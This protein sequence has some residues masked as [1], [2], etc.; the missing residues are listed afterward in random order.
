MTTKLSIFIKVMLS[1]VILTGGTH[2]FLYAQQNG[3]VEKVTDFIQKNQK[4]A[5]E[6]LNLQFNKGQNSFFTNTINNDR[7]VLQPA[8]SWNLAPN[9]NPELNLAYNN[10]GQW[11]GDVNGD[12][13][14]DYIFRGFPREEDT[15]ELEDIGPKTL[16]FFGGNTSE[17][18][19]QIIDL[20]VSPVGDINGD[21][22]ADAVHHFNGLL[23]LGSPDGLQNSGNNFSQPSIIDQ[24]Q[25][26]L[27]NQL[28][29]AGNL[30]GNY[31]VGDALLHNFGGE[32]V[33]FWGDR[34]LSDMRGAE[35]V[36]TADFDKDGDNDIVAASS[37]LNEVVW[38][39]NQGNGNFSVKLIIS[40]NAARAQHVDVADID[41]DGNPDVISASEADGKIA[42][43]QNDGSAG[44]GVEQIVD[45]NLEQAK[46]VKPDDVDGDGDVDLVAASRTT[47]TIVWYENDGTGSFGAP[48]TITTEAPAVWTIIIAD[49][50]SD[51]INDVASASGNFDENNPDGKVAWYANDGSGNYGTQQIIIENSAEFV[52]AFALDAIDLEGDGDQDIVAVGTTQN[53]ILGFENDGSGNF[54]NSF[55]IDELPDFDGLISIITPDLDGD[56]SEDIVAGGFG[57]ALQTISYLNDGSGSF[58]DPTTINVF[59]P[60]SLF[61]D[62]LNGDANTEILFAASPAGAVAWHQNQGNGTMGGEN[63]LNTFSD[64]Q[65]GQEFFEFGNDD[66]TGLLTE[67]IYNTGDVDNDGRNEVFVWGTDNQGTEEIRIFNIEADRQT[68]TLHQKFAVSTDLKQ[69][70]ISQNNIYVLDMEGDGFPEILIRNPNELGNSVVHVFTQDPNNA[71]QYDPTPHEIFT[72]IVLPV[73]DLNADGRLDFH[74][75]DPNEDNSP[76]VGFGKEDPTTPLTLDTFLDAPDNEWRWQFDNL[77]VNPLLGDINNDGI[78]DYVVGHNTFQSSEFV[79]DSTGPLKQLTAGRR[80]VLGNDSGDPTSSFT[81]SPAEYFFD[82]S[83]LVLNLGDVNG[84]GSDDLGFFRDGQNRIDLFF[85][86]GALSQTP[87]AALDLD[88]QGLVFNAGDFNGDGFSDLLATSNGAGFDRVFV[89]HGSSSGYNSQTVINANDFI[90]TDD[91]NDLIFGDNIGDVNND[92]ID[93]FA[94]QTWLQTKPDSTFFNELLV[95]FGGSDISTQ[96]DVRIDFNSILG[97]DGS[98]NAWMG[99]GLTSLGDF[100]GD[101]IDDFAASTPFYEN[102]SVHVF[103][104]SDNPGFNQPDLT[105]EPN[106]EDDGFGDV[107]AGGGDF[108]GDGFGDLVVKTGGTTPNGYQQIYLYTGGT[109]ADNVLDGTLVA[110]PSD[111]GRNDGGEFVNGGFHNMTFVPDYNGDGLDE[112]VISTFYRAFGDLTNAIVYEGRTDI[113]EKMLPQ[114]VLEAENQDSGFGWSSWADAIAVGDFDSNES[115]DVVMSQTADNNDAYESSRQYQYELKAPLAITEAS[116]VPEDQGNWVRVFVEGSLL[117]GTAANSNFAAWSV[118]RLDD[119]TGTWINMANVP[120]IQDGANFTDVRVPVTKPTGEEPAPENTFTFRVTALDASNSVITHTN[121]VEGYAVDNLAPAKVNNVSTTLEG[122]I[123]AMD[124]DPTTA[125]DFQEYVVAEEV[126]GKLQI[127]SPLLTTSDSQAEITFPADKDRVRLVVVARDVH[128][129]ISRK[130]DIIELNADGSTLEINIDETEEVTAEE[131]GTVENT[132]TG[133]KVTIPAGALSEDTEIEIGE[134]SSVPEGADVS[135]TVIHLGPSGTTFADPV[136][137][138]VS[139][140]PNNLPEGVAETELQLVRYDEQEQIWEQLESTVDTEAKTV[141]GFTDKFSGFAAGRAETAVSIDDGENG[142]PTEFTL[143]QNYPNPFNPTTT[144]EYGLPSSAEVRLTVYNVMGQEVATLV[145]ER[146]SAGTHSVNFDASRLSSG[147]YLYRI[148][149]GSFTQTRKLMLVK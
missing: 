107:I 124:W 112:L 93:D 75:G 110:E 133:A 31:G 18:P 33:V 22:F 131:G 98:F 49:I 92:G 97:I 34:R 121:L 87:D 134:F 44:F 14:G 125:N 77:Y 26:G 6:T 118:E 143:K 82:R 52:N 140:D 141:T 29:G 48:K 130:S 149:A 24:G 71:G 128:N 83:P 36:H 21:G 51:G 73:G 139:Y 138:T 123:I 32:F 55:I 38:F 53:T 135:G 54:G 105:L 113:G 15:P 69:G 114:T 129:N 35:S 45:S 89:Y 104:G 109:N 106:I 111:F 127:D 81:S 19:D 9:P 86:G 142:I 27:D 40:N 91:Q 90:T 4:S 13:L 84:D 99:W 50:D 65:P 88:I 57:E 74:M 95:F 3:Q 56:G 11:V 137:V 62:D 122:E 148:E 42:W 94:V 37:I 10:S 60:I 23:L 43:Y 120:A 8:Q 119:S 126:S 67:A 41:G 70:S 47:G 145:N 2:T 16:V 117:D 85:G 66:G 63:L 78:D 115:I 144:I 96:P 46:M 1:V 28:F 7:N 101:G 80:F 25:F 20:W 61:A 5:T 146:Q 103:Y 58:S 116:D 108:N 79:S 64:P 39:E 132:E 68:K 102:G 72:G 147:M 136:E 30:D 100:N 12:G 59:A 17:T 76:Y